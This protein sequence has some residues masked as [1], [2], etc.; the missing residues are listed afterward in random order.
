MRAASVDAQSP[1]DCGA[2]LR[3]GRAEGVSKGGGVTV[4]LTALRPEGLRPRLG[5]QAHRRSP[6]VCSGAAARWFFSAAS[7]SRASPLEGL[8]QG[9]GRG[10]P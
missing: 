9:P 5:A 6:A 2:S 3:R 7:S 10:S 8:G 4:G 1:G